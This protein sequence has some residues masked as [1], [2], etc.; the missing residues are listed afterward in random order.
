MNSRQVAWLLGI[1]LAATLLLVALTE[2]TGLIP[3][4]NG[5]G[6]D[7]EHYAR[8]LE[9]GFKRGTP[10]MRLRPVV[11]LINDEVNYHVFHD[12]LATFRAMNL[13]YAFALAIVLAGLCLRYGAT[14]AAAAA[15]VVNLF[16]CI[17]VAKM[18][19][20]YPTLV[21]LG[22]YVFLAASVWAIVSGHRLAIVLSTVLAVLSREFGAVAVLFGVVRDLR[23]RLSPLVVAFTYAPAV[24]AFFW[25]RYFA[26]T[27]SSGAEANEP[28]LSATGVVAALLRNREWWLD[29]MYVGFSLYF[30]ATLFGGV[31]LLLMTAVRPLA[32]HLREE[33]EWLAMIVPLVIVTALGYVDMWRYGAFLVAVVPP[34]WAWAVASVPARRQWLLLAGVTLATIATQRPWQQMDLTSYFRDW[35]PYFLVVQDRAS[36][37]Q[38]LWPSWRYYLLIAIASFLLVIVLRVRTATAPHPSRA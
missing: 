27:Y 7:G 6:Y 25:I 33:P 38:A 36:A 5:Y 3:V 10:S 12:P 32:S 11:L 20:F 2:I 15:L 28:V 18:F 4:N 23:L 30:L 34:L 19:A 24:A 8:M 21:D 17:S 22:A 14:P 31:S 13:V 16:L 9:A 1:G 35:F 26:A 37:P 29:P